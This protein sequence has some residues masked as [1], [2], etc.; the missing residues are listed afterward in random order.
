M[1]GRALANLRDGLLSLVYPQQCRICGNS[2][3]SWDEGV[4]C[5]AC[6]EDSTSTRLFFD[7]TVCVKCGMPERRIASAATPSTR[8]C[9]ACALHP[10]AY[11]RACGAYSG[12]LEASI[13]SLKEQPHICR[14]LRRV[15]IR[16]FSENIA[17][18][19]SDVVIPVP[20]HASRK[21]ERGFNQAALIAR[22]VSSGLPFDDRSFVRVKRT[23]RHR[24]G[25]DSIDRARSVRRAFAVTRP[26][27]VAGRKVLLIDDVYTTG[28]TIAE[29][30]SA[31][32]DA[33]ADSVNV[34]TIARV[35]ISPRR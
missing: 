10:Y 17:F 13:L 27:R 34:L 20:L 31:L 28:S 1:I 6:W 21:R 3:E 29:A 8:L 5:K 7:Q 32:M 33:G 16:A 24:A 4:A 22:A 15:L 11:A 19:E 26:A 23:E 14:R 12:A 30:A 35:E 25:M 9:G 18:L 2:V